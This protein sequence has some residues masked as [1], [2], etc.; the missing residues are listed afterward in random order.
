MQF[1]S[2]RTAGRA[3]SAITMLWIQNWNMFFD[4]FP[5]TDTCVHAFAW[6]VCVLADEQTQIMPESV[7]TRPPY[8]F[9]NVNIPWQP[10]HIFLYH[11]INWSHVRCQQATRVVWSLPHPT[12]WIVRFFKLHVVAIKFHGRICEDA[13]FCDC[14]VLTFQFVFRDCIGR[15]FLNDVSSC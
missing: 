6:F 5:E 12:S 7:S 11:C 3:R 14:F 15:C 9:Q 1:V 2:N 8:Q 10:C 4:I 13:K